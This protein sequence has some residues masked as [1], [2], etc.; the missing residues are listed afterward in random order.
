MRAVRASPHFR[1]EKLGPGIY[2]AIARTK[3]YGLCNAGIVDLGGRTVVFDSMLTPMAGADLARAAERCTGRKPDWVVNS[4]WHGDHIWGNS[5]FDGGRV[6]SSRKVREVVLRKSRDQFAE[7]R[8][9]FPKELKSMDG[10]K[11]TIAPADRPRVRAWFHGV[12]ESPNPP[13][14]VPPEVT[15]DEELVLE[16]SRR[17]LHLITYGGGHSPSDVFGYLPDERILFA[18]DL[19]M[20]GLHPSIGDGWPDSWMRIL[21]R[22]QGLRPQQ[23]LP[24]H[25][26]MGPGSTLRVVSRYLADLDGMAVR[27][28]RRGL[29]MEE[30]SQIRI[31]ER[32]RD[33]RFAFMFPENVARAYQ[34]ELAYPKP[35]PGR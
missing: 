1:I 35:P 31:P 3:G 32:Y 9:E 7:C 19:A 6:V 8:R 25:G 30:A 18:G 11:S 26:P 33:W 13:R 21:R 14:I 29:S 28:V 10:S 12:L 17:S 34:L 16:G 5:A 22:M 20:V 2:A 4:H 23:V 24:G 27:A 15:F